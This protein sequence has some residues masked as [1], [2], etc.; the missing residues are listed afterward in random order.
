[1]CAVA[2]KHGCQL[3]SHG[4][5][6]SSVL[7]S[8]CV[9]A[10]GQLLATPQA[11]SPRNEALGLLGS[12]LYLPDLY[13]SKP[14]PSLAG[15]GSEGSCGRGMQ[16]YE[17]LKERIVEILFGAARKEGTRFSR[18]LALYLV[19]TLVFS[20]LSSN[21][22]S[23]RLPEGVDILLASLQV[24]LKSLTLSRLLKFCVQFADRGVSVAAIDMMSF[25]TEV[26][27]Q[28]VK[29][30]PSVPLKVLQAICYAIAGEW[31]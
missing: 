23:R 5:S 28:L 11:T 2:V 24:Q 9:L 18:C 6:G 7:L 26:A 10:C 3:F 29:L 4:L 15:V 21:K 1:M 31:L 22:P 14:L 20:E 19:G 13:S 27:P 25:L 30:Y 12:L 17:E 16:Q 8:D